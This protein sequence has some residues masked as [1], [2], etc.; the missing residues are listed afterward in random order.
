MNS[1]PVRR[2]ARLWL[3]AAV[4]HKSTGGCGE[5][6]P[7][8]PKSDACARGYEA[9]VV[10]QKLSQTHWWFRRELRPDRPI[11]PKDEGYEGTWDW[12]ALVVNRN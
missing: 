5:N 11:R 7:I 6:R 1:I 9:L 8:R 2:T 10:K 4:R 3:C 12:K